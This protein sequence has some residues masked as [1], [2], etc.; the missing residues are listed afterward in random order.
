MYTDSNFTIIDIGIGYVITIAGNILIEAKKTF[1]LNLNINLN[2]NI[3][4]IFSIPSTTVINGGYGSSDIVI[5]VFTND[6]ILFNQSPSLNQE[7]YTTPAV[8][9]IPKV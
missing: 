4:Y 6:I 3:A 5:R 8:L 9:F 1:K 2:I 7:I